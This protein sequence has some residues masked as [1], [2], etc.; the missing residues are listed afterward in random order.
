MLVTAGVPITGQSEP[1]PEVCPSQAHLQACPSPHPSH[2]GVCEQHKEEKL[3]RRAGGLERKQGG[4]QLGQQAAPSRAAPSQPC[5]PCRLPWCA[6]PQPGY[7]RIWSQHTSSQ[8][9]M[10]SFPKQQFPLFFSGV[11]CFLIWGTGIHG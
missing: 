5:L 10:A 4:R 6:Q 9:V 2:P 1:E 7:S 11:Y 8:H 3:E